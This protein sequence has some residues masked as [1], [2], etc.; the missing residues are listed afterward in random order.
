MV[1]V[2]SMGIFTVATMVAMH[3][4]SRGILCMT[5]AVA[6]CTIMVFDSFD[7]AVGRYGRMLLARLKWFNQLFKPDV[8]ARGEIFFAKYGGLSIAISRVIPGLKNAM[9]YIVAALCYS[10]RSYFWWCLFANAL[11]FLLC[12]FC[13]F[14]LGTV[15]FVK[16]H[17]DW[18]LFALVLAVL[19][20]AG[21]VLLY[22]K[23]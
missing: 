7:Y 13:G 21:G 22:R 8:L 14:Y 1:T 3:K 20:V 23:Q 16:A 4:V 12:S 6:L 9:A 5:F 17:L 18:I 15:P 10:F 19:A 2:L 11:V